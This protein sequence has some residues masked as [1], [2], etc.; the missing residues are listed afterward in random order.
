[1]DTHS[2]KKRRAPKARD[3]DKLCGVG[4][5]KLVRKTHAGS[6]S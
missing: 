1:M 6:G 3:K 5:L 4:D 2:S